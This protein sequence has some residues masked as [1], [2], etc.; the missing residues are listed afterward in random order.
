M[1]NPVTFSGFA[2]ELQQ[3]KLAFN[4]GFLAR[5]MMSAGK[6]ALAPKAVK[7]IKPPPIPGGAIGK[8]KSQLLT[9]G[10][11]QAASKSQAAFQSAGV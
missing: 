8:A 10:S 3:I 4:E 6:R 7:A 2:D 11:Q 1:I 9:P 5:K